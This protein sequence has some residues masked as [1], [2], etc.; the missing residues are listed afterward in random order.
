M[1]Y[2]QIGLQDDP[3]FEIGKKNY[4]NALKIRPIIPGDDPL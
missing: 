2:Q 3:Q 1:R 4:L